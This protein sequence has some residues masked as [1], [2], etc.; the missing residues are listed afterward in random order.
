MID[1]GM[2]ADRI[3]P[4]YDAVDNGHFA[5]GAKSI[6]SDPGARARFGLPDQYFLA[7]NRFIPKK[8][9]PGLLRG[10]AHY[11]KTT[12]RLPWDL[13]L[14]GD[15]PLRG[16][17]EQLI[18]ELHLTGAV[19]LPGFKQY[20]DLPAY[21]GLASAFVHAS[22]TEQ[23]GLVVNEAMAAGLP[24]IIADRC[25]CAPDLV[26]EG[27]NGFTFDPNDSSA[28][29]KFM[30][31]ISSGEVDLAAFG[32]ASQRIIA[33]WGPDTFAANF[34]RSAETAITTPAVPSRLV[35]RALLWMLTR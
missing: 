6:R 25:G 32:T 14:L 9:L 18:H 29:A 22:T 33:S 23:W 11:R 7:S 17:V 8:N 15:G 10:F 1:L 3:F 4:G 16:E 26:Q 35:D 28:L 13:V 20:C 5:A 21:Y 19:H 30:L 31:K 2:K 24:V 34:W 12:N 27:V